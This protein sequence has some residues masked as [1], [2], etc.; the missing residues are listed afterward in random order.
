MPANYD[1]DEERFDDKDCALA[2][3]KAVTQLAEDTAQTIAD[4]RGRPFSEIGALAVD[5]YG[6]ELPEFWQVWC[7]WHEAGPTPE[8]GDL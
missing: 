6:S 5:T 3:L 1:P 4:F 8:M 7:S 2:F